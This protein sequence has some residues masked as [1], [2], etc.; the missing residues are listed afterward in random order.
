MPCCTQR[1]SCGLCC[2]AARPTTA[3]APQAFTA[4]LHSS[5]DEL[6]QVFL[7]HLQILVAIA[8][9][10]ATEDVPRQTHCKGHRAGH[11][12]VRLEGTFQPSP[13]PSQ[14]CYPPVLAAQGPIQPSMLLPLSLH[15]ESSQLK[16][17]QHS[18]QGTASTPG[19][20]EHT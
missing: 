6:H 8:S 13:L 3:A 4:K 9:D 7:F 18:Q 10:A 17:S 12:M 14:G 1:S 2:A 15:M 16:P 5:R 11:R 20:S 19:L